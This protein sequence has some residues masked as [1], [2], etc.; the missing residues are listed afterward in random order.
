MKARLYLSSVYEVV[1][2]LYVMRDFAQ[3]GHLL[4]GVSI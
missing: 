4:S 1:Y 2:Y 3:L